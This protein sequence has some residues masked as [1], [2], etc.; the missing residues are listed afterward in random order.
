MKQSA[1][2]TDITIATAAVCDAVA[3]GSSI[4]V[5]GLPG[6]G[7]TTV[8][9]RVFDHLSTTFGANSVIV[10]TP[11]REHA[12][13]VRDQLTTSVRSAAAARSVHSYAFGLVSADVAFRTAV[14]AQFVTGADQDARLAE[15]LDGYLRGRVAGPDWPAFMTPQLRSTRV[16]RSQLRDAL[17]DILGLDFSY[18][19]V[20]EL[21]AAYDRPEWAV[22]AALGREYEDLTHLLSDGAVDT[23]EV[24]TKAKRI[25]T[26]SDAQVGSRWPFATEAVPRFILL[27]AVQ[28][29]PDS[30]L[31]FLQA[32]RGVGCTFVL[33]ASPDSATQS[34]RGG[35]GDVFRLRETLGATR[36][37]L[38]DPLDPQARGGGCVS[39]VTAAFVRQS[40]D[41]THVLGH[42]PREG[43]APGDSKVHT[44]TSSSEASCARFIASVIYDRHQAGVAF[45]DIAVISRRASAARVV[46]TELA[47]AGIPV[48]TPAEAL[49][50]NPATAPLMAALAHVA[51]PEARPGLAATFVS[52][53]YGAVDAVAMRRLE[54][55]LVELSGLDGSL[56]EL[57]AWALNAD[58]ELPAPVQRAIRMVAVAEDSQE[59]SAVHAVWNLWEAAGVAQEWRAKALESPT[60]RHS[61]YLD[62]VIRLQTL[63]EKLESLT[64]DGRLSGRDF[65][66]RVQAQEFAQDSLAVTATVPDVVTVT[67]PA[68]VAHTS[69][70]TVIL[71]D[72]HAKV[73]PNPTVRGS[74]FTTPQLIDV[75]KHPE[76]RESLAAPD[77]LTRDYHTRRL[78][79]IRDESALFVAALSRARTMAVLAAV[80]GGGV[81]P[82][83]FYT[84]VES[85]PGVTPYPVTYTDG[86]PSTLAEIA[87]AARFHVD[88]ALSAG[89]DA[90]ATR[91]AS[92]ASALATEHA[93]QPE[94]WWPAIST[95]DP[96]TDNPSTLRVSPS[97]VETFAQ[98]P[99][100]WFLTQNSGQSPTTKAQR[101]GTLIH[102]VAQRH[103]NGGLADMQTTLKDEFDSIEFN[104]DWER[105]RA[106]TTTVNAVEGL[107]DYV[108]HR[109]NALAGVE[110][111]VQARLDVPRGPITISGRVDRLETTAEG[112][113]YIIDFK[114]G[115]N[116]VSVK[117]A[118]EHPQ[119]ATY[120]LALASD[121]V[122]IGDETDHV[123]TT[124][125]VAGGELVYTQK[126]MDVRAQPPIHG[127]DTEALMLATLDEL[128][129]AMRSHTFVATPSPEACR[130]CRF[131]Q[132]CPAKMDEGETEE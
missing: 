54:R 22:L 59:E 117:K 5:V 24:F 38:L 32:L 119:L 17:N 69:F 6:T 84:S 57:M 109:P 2:V 73:W 91:W 56:T 46:S 80:S 52:G 72:L 83:P 37:L 33:A 51:D 9:R 40:G 39:Q 82:G 58:A 113:A 114:S 128:A 55:E 44:H 60:G 20:E 11:S 74:I 4:S 76:L 97:Q 118:T 48:H 86:L 85:F 88:A 111:R 36:T 26:G 130:H 15:Q 95:Y 43:G 65:A 29:F 90:D 122:T 124:S 34:F 49:I 3:Q 1:D 126:N 106:W 79:T 14:P 64:R 66:L 103:P 132:S 68:G 108:R 71:T 96:V 21:A 81:L 12:T 28:D 77:F 8:I 41:A 23:A 112:A 131:V 101:L 98:C 18:D 125:G 30:S 42:V 45:S 47:A 100:K 87:G 31:G 70:D 116:V 120:Q 104:S 92:L 115:K 61:G 94:Q 123:V 78:S 89:D 7:K 127:T 25:V 121:T 75:L 67:T 102:T 62:A 99:L 16:F 27:D 10:L 50:T 35:T 13:A 63:A 93:T 53:A 107:N 129:A 19:Q 105:E 110:L